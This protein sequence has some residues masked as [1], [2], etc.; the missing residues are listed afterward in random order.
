[1]SEAQEV[2]DVR[3]LNWAER[4][5]QEGISGSESQ[6]FWAHAFV[7]GDTQAFPF[8][9]HIR[10]LQQAAKSIS[11]GSHMVSL[12]DFLFCFIFC[13]TEFTSNSMKREL[14]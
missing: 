9:I 3:G 14:G 11:Y 8:E 12:F 6:T 10:Y 1:M 13:L 7:S 2:D 4:T 5:F